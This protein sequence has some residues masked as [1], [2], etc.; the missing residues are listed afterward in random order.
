MNKV[1]VFPAIPF[2]S[3][4]AASAPGREGSELRLHRA[5]ADLREI[6]AAPGNGIPEGVP[7][8]AKCIAVVPHLL[9]G[10]SIFGGENGSGVATCRTEN[11]W[12]AMEDFLRLQLGL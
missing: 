7:E 4:V 6:M 12:S 11:G 10:G 5:G 8:H 2:L 9:K 3:S 1:I